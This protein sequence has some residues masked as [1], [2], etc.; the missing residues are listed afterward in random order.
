MIKNLW[1]NELAFLLNLLPLIST[2]HFLYVSEKL[3]SL[4]QFGPETSSRGQCGRRS[5]RHGHCRPPPIVL[6]Q[7]GRKLAVNWLPLQQQEVL[8]QLSG[9]GCQRPPTGLPQW[10]SW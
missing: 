5:P 1:L 9:L 7:L 4:W 10:L 2:C 8:T 6:H 3:T